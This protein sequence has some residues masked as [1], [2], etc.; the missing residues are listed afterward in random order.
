MV[1]GVFHERPEG[2]DDCGYIHPS[3][4]VEEHGA[5]MQIHSDQGTNFGSKLV[6]VLM[7]LLDVEMTRTVAFKASSDGMV[8]RY[9]RTIVDMVAKLASRSPRS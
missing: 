5:P 3:I 4:E 1:E 6:K 7:K 2:G 8:E 9:N